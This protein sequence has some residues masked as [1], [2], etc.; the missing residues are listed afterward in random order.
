MKSSIPNGHQFPTPPVLVKEQKALEVAQALDSKP[1]RGKLRYLV[2]CKGFSEYPERTAWK[3]ASNLT[4]SPDLF[5]DFH[6]LYPDTPGYQEF[7]FM[8][9]GGEYKL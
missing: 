7:D 9:L 1:K 4:S 5:K 8:V 3:P 2:E 6:T